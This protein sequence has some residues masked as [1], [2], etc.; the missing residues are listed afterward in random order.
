MYRYHTLP[1]ARREGARAGLPR[2]A[3]RL[4]VGRHRR[5]DDAAARASTPDG[6]V[7]RI[8]TRRAGA[9]HQRR[10][11]LRASGST[12]RP[13][14]TTTS[15][16]EA[17]AEILLETARFWASRGD[18]EATTAATTSARSSARTSTTR[19]STTT[20]TRTCMA[21]WNLERG[22]RGRRAARASAGRE[23]WQELAER[24]RPRPTTSSTSGGRRRA[25][26]YTGFDPRD[27]ALRAVP[28]LLR[29]GGHR[30]RR[31]RAAH[32]ADG[33]AARARAHRSA[34]RSS[35]RPTW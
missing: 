19:A 22:A 5:G 24:A 14:A 13:P 9:P 25:A 12:G 6:E 2:R 18:A 33:R 35:S 23:R 28:R 21:Q 26:M 31:V 30:P 10:R 29:P 11:R 4:G 17:G 34:R 15:C 20:P 1:A 16:V 32:R 8:L 3:L 27:R 7:V